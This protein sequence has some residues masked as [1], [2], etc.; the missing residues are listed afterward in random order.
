MPETSN[1]SSLCQGSLSAYVEAYIQH[2]A[3]QFRTLSYSCSQETWML[4]WDK[5]SGSLQVFTE[6]TALGTYTVLCM[7]LATQIPMNTQIFSYSHYG[8][9]I[10]QV[11]L[12][13]VLASFAQLLSIASESCNV[14]QLFL[15]VLD[16]T[17]RSKVIHTGKA[18]SQVKR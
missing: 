7:C 10:P 3:R 8:N 6:H 15:T 14:Q 1:S 16:K 11:F 2:S 4:S 9:L 18:L 12:L 13:N 5:K 17:P